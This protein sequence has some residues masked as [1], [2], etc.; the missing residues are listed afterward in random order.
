MISF[1]EWS[2]TGSR[3]RVAAEFWFGG[4]GVDFVFRVVRVGIIVL[5][6]FVLFI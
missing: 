1:K 6:E 4:L 2:T 3:G 5:G